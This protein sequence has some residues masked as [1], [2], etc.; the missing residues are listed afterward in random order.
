FNKPSEMNIYLKELGIAVCI[1]I[2]ASLFISQ[3]LIPLATSWFIKSRP[4]P[5]T[6]AMLKTES[7]YERLLVI[8]LK[9]RWLTPLILV[10]VLASAWYPFMKVDKNFDANQT[11][12]FVQ[13]N[14]TISENLSLERK[15]QLV[16]QVEKMLEPHRQE[17]MARSIYSF[18]SDQ[19]VMTRVYLK[20][21]EANE[22]NIAGAR[23]A[24]RGM[25]PG[26]AG[27]KL[28]VQE[29]N[30]FWR[31]DR[32]KRIA[33]QIVGE[34][35]DVLADL[36]EEA[37]RRISDVPGLTE[38]FS[39]SEDAQEE[40]HIH[41]DRETAAKMGVNAMQPAQVVGLTFRGQRLQRF[42]TSDGEREMRVV[43]DEKE[44]ESI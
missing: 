24:L 17:L 27:V 43:L 29:N 20:E 41:V 6:K 34:D 18:W 2:L 11:E 19:F 5:K 1:V 7:I 22:K 44:N 8:N 36:A 21:G 26:V 9:H 23:K 15:E 10:G 42:R 39:G 16:T 13:V 31:Q 3:T 30:Q 40:I 28:E 38:P 12:L 25:L 14:Y 4:K 37:K 35:S 32:G 33:L